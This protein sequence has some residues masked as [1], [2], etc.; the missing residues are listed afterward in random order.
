MMTFLPLSLVEIIS[1]AMLSIV[2]HCPLQLRMQL[3]QK[4]VTYL[5]LREAST[6]VVGF[7]CGTILDQNSTT[8]YSLKWEVVDS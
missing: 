8:L 6:K 4:R 7:S 1:N 3:D 2:T 5:V